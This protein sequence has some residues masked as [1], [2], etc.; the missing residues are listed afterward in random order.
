[1]NAA[2]P[3]HCNVVNTGTLKARTIERWNG[4]IAE[5]DPKPYNTELRKMTPNPK[6]GSGC[7]VFF[8][9]LFFRFFFLFFFFV[10]LFFLFFCFFVFSF[11]CF[12]VFLF[13]CFFVFLFLIVLINFLNNFKIF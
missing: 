12:F 11:F 1:M 5:N 4:G 8:C 13:F 9:F 6:T 7:H 3:F 10:F 2:W